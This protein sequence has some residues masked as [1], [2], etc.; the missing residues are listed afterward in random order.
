MTLKYLLILFPFC[1]LP[2]QSAVVGAST[3]ELIEAEKRQLGAESCHPGKPNN[4]GAQA[5][6]WVS[7]WPRASSL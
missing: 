2:E 4:I 7:S 5:G 3:I 1:S 6:M